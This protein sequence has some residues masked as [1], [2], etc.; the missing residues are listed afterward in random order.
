M[1]SEEQPMRIKFEDL[2]AGA[3]SLFIK[4]NKCLTSR[5]G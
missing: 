5:I 3:N 4:K 1:V 2:F